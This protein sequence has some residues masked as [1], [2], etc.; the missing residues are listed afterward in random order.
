MH[1]ENRNRCLWNNL[2]IE[3]LAASHPAKHVTIDSNQTCHCHDLAS[4]MGGPSIVEVVV[5]APD[6][7]VR[8]EDNQWNCWRSEWFVICWSEWSW[9]GG[10]WCGGLCHVAIRDQRCE[11]GCPSRF[12][13]RYTSSV[14]YPVISDT[15]A[16][17]YPA[18]PWMRVCGFWIFLPFV[19]FS[20]HFQKKRKRT[21]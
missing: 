5:L 3:I 9:D 18:S 1:R 21:F 8:W 14:P 2:H 17:P 13:F 19:P 15:H 16:Y 12:E 4:P 20:I 11:S 10:G 7:H 6:G